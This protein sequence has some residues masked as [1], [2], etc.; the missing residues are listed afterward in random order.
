MGEP[1][2]PQAAPRETR[3]ASVNEA[4][5]Y[6]LGILS[7]VPHDAINWMG[8]I[9]PPH[10]PPPISE[11]L[12]MPQQQGTSCLSGHFMKLRVIKVSQLSVPQLPF[13]AWCHFRRRHCGHFR[14]NEHQAIRRREQRFS[15]PKILTANE[16]SWQYPPPTSKNG[17]THR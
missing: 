13:P 10:T 4:A 6:R 9:P 5:A 16:I 1:H 17:F 3:E 14:L 12:S 2:A 11:N 15:R 7:Y 8:G